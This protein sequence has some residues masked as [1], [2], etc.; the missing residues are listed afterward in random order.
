MA[1]V[2]HARLTATGSIKK[3]AGKLC[4]WIV[5]ASSAGTLQINN[6]PNDA[7]GFNV[8][9]PIPLVAGAVVNLG[10]RGVDLSAG[11]YAT[12]G[13]TADVTFLYA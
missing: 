2:Y 9:G 11:I 12:I 13:G 10:V 6:S 3:N 5:N 4:G 8:F 7:S 1:D